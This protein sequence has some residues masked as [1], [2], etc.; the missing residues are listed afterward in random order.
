MLEIL[1]VLSKCIYCNTY[2][3]SRSGITQPLRGDYLSWG[4]PQPP[5]VT[6]HFQLL[7][8]SLTL[9]FVVTNIT[10]P[11]TEIYVSRK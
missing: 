5:R 6:E 2:Q 10:G 1:Q 8:I 11:P 4:P 3:K 7:L 9:F